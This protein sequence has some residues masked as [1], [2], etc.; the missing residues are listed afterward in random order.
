MNRFIFTLFLVLFCVSGCNDNREIHKVKEKNP[1]PLK[2]VVKQKQVEIESTPTPS[3]LQSHNEIANSNNEQKLVSREEIEKE[4]QK[5][6]EDYKRHKAE[7]QKE[8][9]KK[10]EELTKAIEKNPN[11][12]DLYFKREDLYYDNGK[13]QK[14]LADANRMIELNPKSFDGYNRKGCCYIRMKDFD[15]AIKSFNN[16]RSVDSKNYKSYLNLGLV[17]V[18]L[19]R[20]D[21][22][23]E[24][25]KKL[26]QFSNSPKAKKWYYKCMAELYLGKN[27]LK[28][29]FEYSK[30][31]IGE[32]DKEITEY[33]FISYLSVKLNSP[34]EI[35]KYSEKLLEL[36]HFNSFGYFYLAG[37]Y[38]N[39]KNYNLAELNFKK[40]VIIKPDQLNSNQALGTTL[41][42]QKLP[43][44][45]LKYLNKAIKLRQDKPDSPQK[46]FAYLYR[47]NA[48]AMLKKTESAK[49]DYIKA[50]RLDPEGE[51][52]KLADKGLKQLKVYKFYKLGIG[53]DIENFK[54]EDIERIRSAAEKYFSLLKQREY[55]KISRM[56][57]FPELSQQYLRMMKLRVIATHQVIPEVFGTLK[58]YKV[59]PAKDKIIPL[60]FVSTLFPD[61]VNFKPKIVTQNYRVKFTKE[62]KEETL[63]VALH[64]Q[65]YDKKYKLVSVIY[66]GIDSGKFGLNR[67][68]KIMMKINGK[69]QKEM[70]KG[71]SNS[72]K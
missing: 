70:R 20:F 71:V 34:D 66:N 16:A 63:Y 4:L 9:E 49:K 25:F 35:K 10:L 32:D 37:Y 51:A 30:K 6:K 68:L 61:K 52:G 40:V 46:A 23:E 18:R 2:T 19:K 44:E 38:F 8:Y 55:K 11:N 53:G 69:M 57:K 12:F 60:L 36:D 67:S 14:A 43:K 31:V 42:Y 54:K 3:P 21:E 13:F 27:Q 39:L 41:I 28:K 59:S 58:E 65:I 33:E 56:F 26:K 72:T 7:K 62:K 22:A 15:R 47:G 50:K 5:F 64:F 45:A 17:Y 1:V 24:E 48:Y 29:S